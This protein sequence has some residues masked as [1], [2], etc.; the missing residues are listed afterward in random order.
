MRSSPNVY[1][2]TYVVHAPILNI[3]LAKLTVHDFSFVCSGRSAKGLLQFIISL[4]LSCSETLK[5]I[6][7]FVHIQ[8]SQTYV[9]CL[10]LM[11]SCHNPALQVQTSADCS[12]PEGA[13]LHS[14]RSASSAHHNSHTGKHRLGICACLARSNFKHSLWVSTG[15][16]PPL[17]PYTA[18]LYRL[19]P[20]RRIAVAQPHL[21]MALLAQRNK[22]SGCGLALPFQT[23]KVSWVRPDGW[24]PTL[25]P[26][27]PPGIP[28]WAL[29]NKSY[30][31]TALA[32]E[33]SRTTGLTFI[34]AS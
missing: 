19:L 12:H 3:Q 32:K 1:W 28:I 21:P 16:L 14:S 25:C 31:N 17:C 27:S 7:T 9:P 10:S 20:P 26:M 2:L 22:E 29:K 34:T 8:Y 11:D 6:M 30:G 13:S 5:N 33:L 24:K 18:I 23:V 4:F 15:T